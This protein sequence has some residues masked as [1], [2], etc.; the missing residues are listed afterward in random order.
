MDKIADPLFEVRA[1]LKEAEDAGLTVRTACDRLVIRG[2]KRAEPIAKRL[3][4]RKSHAI[5]ALVFP[6][7]DFS[8]WVRRPDVDGRM[9]WEAPGLAEA[10][11]W[12]A[13]SRFEEL[14]RN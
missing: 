12:W 5:V 3:L 11:R 2:S 10:D 14:Y 7:L 9:G 13:R 8:K 6:K 1:L 4:E